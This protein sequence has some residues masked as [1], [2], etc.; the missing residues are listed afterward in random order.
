MLEVSGGRGAGNHSKARET[1]VSRR[2][3]C[4]LYASLS[5][6]RRTSALSVAD[7]Y[8]LTSGMTYLGIY[9]VGSVGRGGQAIL[10]VAAG[11]VV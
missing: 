9:R 6:S 4:G 5:L 8:P 3:S 7:D 1:R 2:M 10:G 11:S